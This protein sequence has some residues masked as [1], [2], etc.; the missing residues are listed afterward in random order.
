VVLY[1]PGASRQARAVARKLGISQ[2]EPVDSA[3]AALAGTATVVVVVGADRA[4]TG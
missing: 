3:S 4:T 1:R 2:I